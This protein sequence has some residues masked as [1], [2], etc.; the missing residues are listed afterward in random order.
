MYFINLVVS[1]SIPGYHFLVEYEIIIS[2]D[3][4]LGDLG[5]ELDDSFPKSSPFCQL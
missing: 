4:N 5:L 1:R 3:K 2:R